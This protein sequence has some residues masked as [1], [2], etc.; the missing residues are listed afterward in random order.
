MVTSSAVV[1]KL[2]G[3]PYHLQTLF[4]ST[5]RFI[6]TDRAIVKGAIVATVVSLQTKYGAQ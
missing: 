3:T 2:H 4:G 5:Q 1:D 6:T